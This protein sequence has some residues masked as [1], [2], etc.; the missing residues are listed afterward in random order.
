ML[1]VRFFA[2][3]SPRKEAWS[4]ILHFKSILPFRYSS[5]GNFHQHQG[6]APAVSDDATG[7]APPQMF[8]RK[9]V[10]VLILLIGKWINAVSM[11]GPTGVLQYLPRVLICILLQILSLILG[12]DIDLVVKTPT[13]PIW[14]TEV[15]F[16][17]QLLHQLSVHV[18]SRQQQ[19]RISHRVPATVRESWTG[20]TLPSSTR[21]QDYIRHPESKWEIGNFTFLYSSSL[22]LSQIMHTYIYIYM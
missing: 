11:T 2:T 22:S 6:I 9:S 18:N 5:I 4:S 8:S 20:F 12:Q 21:G 10:L 16:W 7:N 14:G 15:S 3:W 17:V 1:W 19:W 13:S